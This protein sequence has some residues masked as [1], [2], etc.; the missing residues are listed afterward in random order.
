MQVLSQPACSLK[1]PLLRRSFLEPVRYFCTNAATC[2][3]PSVLVAVSERPAVSRCGC[4]ALALR[5]TIET[6]VSEP[7]PPTPLPNG[8]RRWV[9]IACGLLA[10]GLATLGAFLPVLPTTPFL[11]VAAACFA[12][13]SPSFHRRLLANPLF[14]EYIAQW[15][16]DHTIPLTAKRKAWGLLLLSFGV[17]IALVNATWLRVLLALIGLSIGL[18][19]AWL[20]TTQLEELDIEPPAQDD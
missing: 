12:R 7:S 17:S 2:A 4:P 3:L 1:F 15:Q 6:A 9:L 18:L 16:S 8:F 13:S 11:I 10:T 14:G 19:L 20:P 5:R